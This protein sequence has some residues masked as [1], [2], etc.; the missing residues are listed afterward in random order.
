MINLQWNQIKIGKTKYHDKI[1][2]EKALSENFKL[3]IKANLC[4][5]FFIILIFICKYCT[6][7]I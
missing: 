7:D 4:N 2:D 5:V 1:A 6:G 3:V